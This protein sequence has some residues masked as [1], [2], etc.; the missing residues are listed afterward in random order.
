MDSP[1][2]Q[3]STT[4]SEV[5]SVSEPVSHPAEI[6]GYVIDTP[7]TEGSSY[8]A[9]G[10]GGRGVV[11]KK[12][13]TD[14][15]LRGLLHPSIRERLSR[16]REL[17]HPGVANLYGVG[18][19]GEHAYLIWDYVDGTPFE[20]WSVAENRTPRE[21]ALLARELIVS[22]DS[23][24]MQ[25]IVHGAI[26]G[27]NVIVDGAGGVRLTHVSPLLYTDPLAD[28]EAVVAVLEEAVERR[29]EQGTPLGE[30]L[31]VARREQM[32]LRTLAAH[33]SALLETREP[34]V[35]PDERQADDR[36]TRRR[37]RLLAVLVA[38]AGLLLAYGVWQAIG[39][40]VNLHTALRLMPK[41][42]G[43]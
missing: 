15:L 36:Q 27:S 13:D 6:C 8:L 42:V 25:G 29:E 9:I 16:V 5:T 28:V 30:L 4:G 39:S 11:L 34:D 23:L 38:A 7:L 19:E 43:K 40:G 26:S 20:R 17:A 24:H 1:S 21:L 14:C 18:R 32:S 41:A 10:P 31:A 22:V 12:L 33:V 35:A 2:P 3:T 37:S